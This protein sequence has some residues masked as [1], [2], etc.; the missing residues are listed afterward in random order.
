M[1]IKWVVISLCKSPSRVRVP[2]YAVRQVGH[3]PDGKILSPGWTL[4]G[5]EL[6]FRLE[7]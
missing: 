3:K 6:D 2:K 4:V 7:L 1:G 5:A